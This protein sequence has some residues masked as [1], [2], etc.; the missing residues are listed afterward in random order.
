MPKII[1]A[2]MT[3]LLCFSPLPANAKDKIT[4]ATQDFPPFSYLENGE[5][6]GP[7]AAII[8]KICMKLE[9][10]YEIIL[11]PWRRSQSMAK[12]GEVQA[13]FLIGKNKQRE[14][15][16]IFSPP[17][18]NTEYGFFE[19][20]TTPINYKN[21]YSLRGKRVGVY[22]PSNT[23]NELIK[24]SK[25]LRGR[26]SIDTTPDDIAPF[27][28]LSKCR[29][30]AVYSNKEVGFAMIEKLNLDN[31][32][33]AGAN[34]DINYYIGFSKEFAPPEFVKKFNKELENMKKTGEL[35]LI[36]NKFG[37]QAAHEAQ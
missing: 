29:V 35:Q 6:Q 24:I 7:G 34:K 4:F 30:D 16:I 18:I 11:R 3:L 19:C 31:I 23:S 36:L 5:V 14:S 27:K 21:I 33:F 1:F 9:T 8:K 32:Q 22:G 13:I 17:I 15:W 12:K 20:T 28:K 2:I 25:P 37:M 10:D 26:I